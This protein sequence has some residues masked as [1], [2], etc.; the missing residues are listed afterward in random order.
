VGGDM[1]WTLIWD[2]DLRPRFWDPDFGDDIGPRFGTLI[3]VV[4]WDP[5]L[6]P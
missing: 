1:I 3:W 2:P 5:D 4:I 6:E